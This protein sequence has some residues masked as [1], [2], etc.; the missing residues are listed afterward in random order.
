MSNGGIHWYLNSTV[1][2]R[3][4][5]FHYGIE[6]DYDL[7]PEDPDMLGR[8]SFID[9]AGVEKVENGFFIVVKKVSASYSAQPLY[10][11]LIFLRQ[12]AS[13]P[14]NK[15]Y[16]A[17]FHRALTDDCDKTVSLNLWAY[18]WADPPKLMRKPGKNFFAP[19]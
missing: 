11:K 4:A 10:E 7:N 14:A 17:W 2:G 15:E 16:S 9:V 19:L 8:K 12:D 3:V 5:K 13:I 6:A 18:R 1:V